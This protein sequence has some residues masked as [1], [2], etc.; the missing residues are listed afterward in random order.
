MD[1]GKAL[2]AGARQRNVKKATDIRNLAQ[3][4]G[5]FSTSSQRTKDERNQEGGS[6]RVEQ[7]ARGPIAAARLQ[8]SPPVGIDHPSSVVGASPCGGAGSSAVRLNSSRTESSS[9]DCSE[10]HSIAS[11]SPWNILMA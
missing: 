8:G 5:P 6:A 9:A 1:T 10:L 2:T 7:S 4:F 11:L 3:A